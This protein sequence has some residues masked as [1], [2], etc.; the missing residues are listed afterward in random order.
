MKAISDMLG[1][2]IEESGV[3]RGGSLTSALGEGPE[4]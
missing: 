2:W 4:S 1:V 3:C